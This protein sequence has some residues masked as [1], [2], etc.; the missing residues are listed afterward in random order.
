MRKLAEHLETQEEKRDFK[1]YDKRKIKKEMECLVEELRGK[2]L[3]KA[4]KKRASRRKIMDVI[5]QNID[6]GMNMFNKEDP[7]FEGKGK[8]TKS[9][10]TEKYGEEYA[11]NKMYD[12]LL[13]CRLEAYTNNKYDNKHNV[14]IILEESKIRKYEFTNMQVMKS[15]EDNRKKRAKKEN[16]VLKK[17]AKDIVSKALVKVTDKRAGVTKEIEEKVVT[18]TQKKRSGLGDAISRLERQSAK[19]MQ[20]AQRKNNKDCDKQIEKVNSKLN[21]GRVNKKIIFDSTNSK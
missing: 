3:D 16:K 10:S 9:Q 17:K 20:K 5:K 11:M 14:S 15:V 1:L 21:Q 13:S 4:A 6:K 19:K 12:P 2:T 18:T 8:G 7:E